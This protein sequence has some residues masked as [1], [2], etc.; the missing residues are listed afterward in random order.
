MLSALTSLT[1]GRRKIV[2]WLEST[3][4]L[5]SRRALSTRTYNTVGSDRAT[6]TTSPAVSVEKGFFTSRPRLEK[7]PCA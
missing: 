1:A 4:P 6:A 3:K 5:L 7:K 2:T